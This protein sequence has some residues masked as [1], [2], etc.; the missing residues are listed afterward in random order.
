MSFLTQKIKNTILTLC[1][2]LEFLKNKDVKERL[3]EV[4]LNKLLVNTINLDTSVVTYVT[5]PNSEICIIKNNKVYLLNTSDFDF[6]HK[7][8][9]D[10]IKKEIIEKL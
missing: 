9:N 2:K 10:L 1:K 6:N 8:I 7:E 3:P 5:H 4:K